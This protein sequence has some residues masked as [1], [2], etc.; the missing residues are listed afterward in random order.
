[1]KRKFSALFMVM[2]LLIS[3]AVNTYAALPET[4]EPLWDNI[5]DITNK[6]YFYGTSG[7]ARGTVAGKDG[8][9]SIAGT[10][11][12]YEET[13]YGW[14]LIGSDSGSTGGSTLYLSVSFT[15]E[16]GTNYKSVLNV[17]VTIG[18]STESESST[19]YATAP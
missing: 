15:P 6:F 1:M 3:L 17:S 19:E 4:V 8:A 16:S 18:N 2:V 10:L 13:D 14:L 5:S 7:G 12:V 9:T 11:A